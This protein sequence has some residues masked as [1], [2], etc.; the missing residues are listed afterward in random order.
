MGH[1][2]D[3]VAEKKALFDTRLEAYL[4]G[5][6]QGAGLQQACA[7]SLAAG[8]KRLRPVLALL[9]CEA[10]GGRPEQALDAALA[11]EMIHTFSLI[12]DDLPAIDNDDLRRGKPTCHKVFGEATAVLAGDALVFAAFALVGASAYAPEVRADLTRK[13][14]ELGGMHGLI[15]GEY[16]DI[17]AE[18]QTLEISQIE[19]I[20]TDKTGKLFE[21]A[22]YAGGRIAGGAPAELD[23]LQRCGRHLGL[24]FQAVDDILDV[25][26]SS[27]AMGKT[28]GKDLLQDKAT[29]VKVLGLEAA[30]D[31][32]AR[33]TQGAIDA[34]AAIP[35]AGPL[36]A[37]ARQ[38]LARMS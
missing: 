30:R 32:A 29:L 35:A 24:A 19:A 38:I 6:D 12:H 5:L 3:I 22:L 25:T 14:A 37:L 11:V 7:Y 1:T 36:R 15:A 4:A 27:D 13:M 23:A 20:Y 17:M 8:G 16:A 2:E 31:W 28:T 33:Q 26:S 18:G 10:L 21:L 34:L 9:A